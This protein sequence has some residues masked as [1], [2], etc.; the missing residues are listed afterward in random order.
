MSHHTLMK[1]ASLMGFITAGTGYAFHFRVQRNIRES[2]TYKDAINALRVHKKAVPY[3][4]EPTQTSGRITYGVGQQIPEGQ[5][6]YK[7][8]KVPL[9]GTNTKGILYYE[10]TSSH[11]LDDKFVV[12]KIEITFDNIPGKTFVIRDCKQN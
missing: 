9:R 8:F 7:W 12:S 6:D 10:I 5:T 3:L 4:G 1:V 11:E 2:E